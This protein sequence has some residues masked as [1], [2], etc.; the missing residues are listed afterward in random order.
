[1]YELAS[2]KSAVPTLS[3]LTEQ[4]NNSLYCYNYLVSRYLSAPGI[5]ALKPFS[6]NPVIYAL[7]VGLCFRSFSIELSF[8]I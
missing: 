8:F 1:M 7:L 3:L 5:Q 4:D 2:G 6:K